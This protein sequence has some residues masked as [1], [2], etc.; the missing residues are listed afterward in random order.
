MI[1]LSLGYV[2][3]ARWKAI[4]NALGVAS[5]GALA[6]LILLV[7]SVALTKTIGRPEHLSGGTPGGR[8]AGQQP[9]QKAKHLQARMEPAS[10]EQRPGVSLQ[11]RS[12]QGNPT[13]HLIKNQNR[14]QKPLR[15]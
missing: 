7:L 6:A 12:L 15:C 1:P 5:L 4:G 13:E 14:P 10:E 8:L 3:G 11:A 9:Q 2:S